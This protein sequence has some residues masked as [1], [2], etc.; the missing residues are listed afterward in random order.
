[1]IAR[2]YFHPLTI[3][4]MTIKWLYYSLGTQMNCAVS[5]LLLLPVLSWPYLLGFQSSLICPSHLVEH[6]YGMSEAPS[7]NSWRIQEAQSSKNPWIVQRLR[8]DK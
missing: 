7:Q 4:R 1:M 5:P 3:A 8:P 6:S 2:Q